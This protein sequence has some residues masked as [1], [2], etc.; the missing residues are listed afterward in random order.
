MEF[1]N[2]GILAPN[3]IPFFQ[4]SIAPPNN[5]LISP[6]ASP[7]PILIKELTETPLESKKI[8]PLNKGR[9]SSP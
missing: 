6:L 7:T 3:T 5:P 1:W 9:W 8:L 2:D 4:Y